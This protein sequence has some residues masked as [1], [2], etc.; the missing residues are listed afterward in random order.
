MLAMN[1][2]TKITKEEVW[3]AAPGLKS[4]RRVRLRLKMGQLN[5]NV[6]VAV[7]AICVG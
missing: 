7:R 3:M 4:S 5:G 1:G 2:R 6:Q